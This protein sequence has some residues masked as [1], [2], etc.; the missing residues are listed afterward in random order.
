MTMIKKKKIQIP[1]ANVRGVREPITKPTR[2]SHA[3]GS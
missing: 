3:D 2:R 1:T